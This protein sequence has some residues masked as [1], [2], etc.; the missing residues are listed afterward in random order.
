M[1][2]SIIGP[3]GCGKGTQAKLLSEKL[4][5]PAISMGQIL[6][7]EVLTGSEDGKAVDGFI[8]NGKLV[9][10][11]L[12]FKVFSKALKDPKLGNGFV[13]DGCPRSLEDIEFIESRDSFGFTKV[14]HLDTTDKTSIARMMNRVKEDQ[15][16]GKKIR[17]DDNE[18]GMQN[19]LNFYH[20]HIEP[21]LASLEERKILV[22]IDN[23]RSIAE[24]HED[25]LKHVKK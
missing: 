15:A 21:V 6:R 19:R 18:A 13:I 22:R 5:L 2:I 25:I 23:E 12:L 9:P 7:D 4:N 3:S 14:F 10:P 16:M 11:D 24:I 17:S 1:I 20:E 8:S